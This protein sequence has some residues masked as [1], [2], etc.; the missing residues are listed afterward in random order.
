MLKNSLFVLGFQQINSD[1][2]HLHCAL[3]ATNLLAVLGTKLITLCLI[4]LPLSVESEIINASNAWSFFSHYCS[5]I[6][7]HLNHM[8]LLGKRNS[9]TS[10]Y[11]TSYRDYAI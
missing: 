4:E 1:I 3:S 11:T 5:F 2:N 9:L 6:S 8:V 7:T 10:C